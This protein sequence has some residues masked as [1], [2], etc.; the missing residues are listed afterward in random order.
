MMK[1]HTTNY[2][3]TFIEVAE[4][5]PAKI[6][7]IPPAKKAETIAEIQFNLIKNNPY[8]FTSDDV[9][10]EIFALKKN[11]TDSEKPDERVKF[12]SKGQPC[13]RASPLSK[14]YGFG[15]H[16]DQNSKI[17]LIALESGEYSQ[18]VSDDSVKKIK[19]MRSKKA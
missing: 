1:I 10:F 11:L 9:I 14:K 3:N 18:L 5:C 17:A 2:Q 8:L 19:A 16:H 13:L 15:I 12:F 6:S 4:D 7:Q